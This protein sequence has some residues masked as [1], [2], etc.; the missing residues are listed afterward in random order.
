MKLTKNTNAIRLP[1]P[2]CHEPSRPY[3]NVNWESFT[4]DVFGGMTPSDAY[5]EHYPHCRGWKSVSIHVAASKLR[6]KVAPRIEWLQEQVASNAILTK[7]KLAEELSRMFLVT[8][9]DFLSLDQDGE[10]FVQITKESMAC[11]AL[12]KIKA[13]KI[14]DDAGN[15]VMGI[16]L[17]EIELESKV[18]VAVALAKL[19]GYDKA[20]KNQASYNDICKA[21]IEQLA[22]PV[23]DDQRTPITG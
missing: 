10:P 17:Y 1:H 16:H 15:T 2:K 4:Q 23:P 7:T 18:P 14:V 9:A 12:K 8:I 21:L 5:R 3:R 6:A 22:P 13:K 20:D 19:M 11:M